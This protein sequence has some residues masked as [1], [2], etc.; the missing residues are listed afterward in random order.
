MGEVLE[1]TGPEENVE[2]DTMS[3]HFAVWKR[4][5][6]VYDLKKKKELRLFIHLSNKYIYEHLLH[7]C[8]VLGP[9]DI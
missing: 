1:A 8:A 3:E 6:E 4:D 2:N 7:S 5:Y 9:R